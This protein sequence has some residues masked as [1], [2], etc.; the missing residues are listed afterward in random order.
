MYKLYSIT[1]EKSKI[2][3][4]WKAENGKIYIDKIKIE[5]LSGE[6]LYF[7][8]KA[9]FAS[10]EKAVFYRDFE[11]AIIESASG[12]KEVLRHCITWEENKLKPSL[13]KILLALHGGFTV[14]KNEKGFL[15]EL[16][17]A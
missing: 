8:K 17:K 6:A 4:F 10:G 13:V 12:E 3:G 16:W 1:K 11:N 2:R 9:L 15:I 14:Y 5:N 7:A